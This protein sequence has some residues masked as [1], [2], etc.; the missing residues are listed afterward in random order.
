MN[1]ACIQME[2]LVFLVKRFHQFSHLFLCICSL[3]CVQCGVGTVAIDA[4][5][6]V[7]VVAA[8]FPCL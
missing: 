6:V 7:V 8:I 4:I 5:V 1:S 2:V 3:L